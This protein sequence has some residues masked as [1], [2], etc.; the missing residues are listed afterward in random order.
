MTCDE[1]LDR[2]LALIPEGDE[3]GRYTKAFRI[4]LLNA[5]LDINEGRLT[6]LQ[7]VRKRLGL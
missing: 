2:L 4:G 6:D 5:Y 1:V 7:Q 3:E